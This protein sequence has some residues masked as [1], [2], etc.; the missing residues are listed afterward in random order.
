MFDPYEYEEIDESFESD[1]DWFDTFEFL[2]G[3]ER[4]ELP[5]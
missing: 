1:I 3:D 4:K 2:M 5:E